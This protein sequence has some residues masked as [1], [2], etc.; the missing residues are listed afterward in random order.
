MNFSLNRLKHNLENVT[1]CIFTVQRMIFSKKGAVKIEKNKQ[2][3]S[4]KSISDDAGIVSGE[5]IVKQ[6]IVEH[7]RRADVGLTIVRAKY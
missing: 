7:N 3:L 2:T 6:S 4:I 1:F 5:G